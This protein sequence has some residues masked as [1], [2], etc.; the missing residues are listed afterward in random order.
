MYKEMIVMKDHSV[1][2]VKEIVYEA[3]KF[4][5]HIYIICDNKKVNA[6]SI[7]GMLSLSLKKGD[8]AFIEAVGDDAEDVINS[9]SKLI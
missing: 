6:K 9:L 2:Y 7:M 4:S 5:S 1:S 8:I 3:S